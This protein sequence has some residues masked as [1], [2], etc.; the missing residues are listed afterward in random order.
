MKYEN[1]TR[2]EQIFKE[3]DL[4]EAELSGIKNSGKLNLLSGYGD[5]EKKSYWI[6]SGENEGHTP[7]EVV[8][9]KFVN[10]LEATIQGMIDALKKELV[11]L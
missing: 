6:R 3:I 4:L 9:K 5:S 7:Q 1:R 11:A 10:E 8:V 2:V